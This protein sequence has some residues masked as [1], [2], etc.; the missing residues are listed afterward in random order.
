VTRQA[1]VIDS[2]A[3]SMPSELPAIASTGTPASI[4]TAS[5]WE[6]RRRPALV[7]ART[8]MVGVSMALNARLAATSGSAVTMLVTQG[9]GGSVVRIT[10]TEAIEGPSSIDIDRPRIEALAAALL[11]AARLPSAEP[12]IAIEP[13]PAASPVTV[14]NVSTPHERSLAGTRVMVAA[15]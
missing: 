13:N 1:T 14:A 11:G 10:A 3:P 12:S 7:S 15:R 8:W 4:T 9:I 6:G 2:V 5:R